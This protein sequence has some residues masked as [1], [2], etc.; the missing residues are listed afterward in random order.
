MHGAAQRNLISSQQQQP[1]CNRKSVSQPVK[2]DRW[3]LCNERSTNYNTAEV[4][5][6]VWSGRGDSFMDC[7]FCLPTGTNV[8]LAIRLEGLTMAAKTTTAEPERKW[9]E[10][11][12]GLSSA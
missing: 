9:K 1:K 10:R 7:H 2:V 8:L 12:R 3:R 11:E 5:G 6:L 4:G